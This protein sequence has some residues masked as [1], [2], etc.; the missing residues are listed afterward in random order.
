MA[1]K[2]TAWQSDSPQHVSFDRLVPGPA[3]E[4]LAHSRSSTTRKLA[5]ASS[6]S[7]HQ[8]HPDHGQDAAKGLDERQPL[9]S[10]VILFALG[11]DFNRYYE[12]LVFTAA[13]GVGVLTGW[14]AGL[15]W[16]WARSY[17][18][19]QPASSTASTQQTAGSTQ[20]A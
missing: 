17:S 1:R 12:P 6:P 3:R 4:K 11:V 13:A 20:P 9:A 7:A 5:I 8:H 14:I 19:Q 10:V 16:S 2:G 15:V 18:R